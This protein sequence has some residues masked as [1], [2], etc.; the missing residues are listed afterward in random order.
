[1]KK[2]STSSTGA[3][4]PSAN[5]FCDLG[6]MSIHSQ[7]Q[8]P[9]T[10]VNKGH[11]YTKNLATGGVDE[12]VQDWKRE[13][14]TCM[15]DSEYLLDDDKECECLLNDDKETLMQQSK[16]NCFE[17]VIAVK[18][19]R[20]CKF[21]QK[22]F[23]TFAEVKENQNSDS[24]VADKYELIKDN[25]GNNNEVA[26]R[27][28]LCLTTAC[29][30]TDDFTSPQDSETNKLGTDDRMIS[31]EQLHAKVCKDNRLSTEQQED[32]YN[33]LAKYRQH[34]TKQPGKCTQFVYEFKIEGSVPHSANSRPIPFALRNQVHEQI[35]AMLKDGILE[36]SHSAYLNP[37]TLIVREGKAVCI[38]LDAR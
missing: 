31:E 13:T 37:I 18:N 29:P 15:E 27:S 14:G 10:A 7:T 28:S 6:L 1:M 26:D 2:Y 3:K 38:C 25:N 12:S 24:L 4:E 32:L 21:C 22:S 33:V 20:G 30:K 16:R 8:H 36:E 9:S 34:L 11:C 19:E 35:Q 5:S 23:A 17:K